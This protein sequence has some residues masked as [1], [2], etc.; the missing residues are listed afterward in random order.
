MNNKNIFLAFILAIGITQL[1]FSQEDN[2]DES[3]SKAHFGLGTTLFNLGSYLTTEY[4]VQNSFYFVVDAGK[5]MR[6]EPT[7]G[8][9]LTENNKLYA[10]GLGV[11]YKVPK[12]KFNILYGIRYEI[13]LNK[14]DSYTNSGFPGYYSSKKAVTDKVMSVAPTIGGEYYFIKHFSIGTEIQLRFL[15]A[16]EEWESLNTNSTVLLRFYF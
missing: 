6:L 16:S 12:E 7:F 11:F 4:S 13:L 15:H 1:S 8:L 10:L 14:Y 3:S 5:R 2:E 9:S